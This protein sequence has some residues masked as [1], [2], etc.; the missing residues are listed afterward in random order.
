[1][2]KKLAKRPIY[3]IFSFKRP[4]F[5]QKNLYFSTYIIYMTKGE[6]P[7]GKSPD[8][9]KKSL[10]R[11]MYLYTKYFFFQIDQIPQVI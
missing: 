3:R 5:D 6:S 2:G 10:C 7:G 11:Y 4:N 8:N 1:M 9:K